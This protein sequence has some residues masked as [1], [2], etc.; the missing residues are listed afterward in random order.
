MK[1][2]YVSRKCTVREDT[3]QYTEKKFA[4]LERFFTGDCTLHV[5]YTFE[6]ED[7]FRVEVT[8]EYKG[9]IFRAQAVGSDFRYCIDQLVD[10]LI[11]QI[12]KHKTKLEKKI[13]DSSFIFEDLQHE[14][15]EEEYK[16]TRRKSF[17]VKPMTV[18]E[19][20]LQMNMLGHSFFVFKEDDN[21]VKVVYRRN[22]GNYGVIEAD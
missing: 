15:E 22:D 12:R 3:K 2:N 5:I 6:K 17:N 20:I 21:L 14:S 16:V 4:K 9:I 8:A 10:I 1:F 11:R 18:D 7:Q 19:A 13:K